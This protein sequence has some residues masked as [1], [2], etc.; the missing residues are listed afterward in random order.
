MSICL[1]EQE[2]VELTGKQ[3][4]DAQR[5]A[6]DAMGISYRVRFDGSTMVLRTDVLAPASGDRATEPDWSAIGKSVA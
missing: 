4:R 5:R 1:P 2:T 3:R 6:L